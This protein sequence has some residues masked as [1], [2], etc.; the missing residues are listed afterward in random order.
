MGRTVSRVN[1]SLSVGGGY[2]QPLQPQ[3]S[4]H[5][6]YP[7]YSAPAMDSESERFPSQEEEYEVYD[8]DDDFY[9]EHYDD[10][11]D[12]I[13]EDYIGLQGA[14]CD[15]NHFLCQT[16]VRPERWKIFQENI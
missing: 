14:L 3:Y 13:Y 16:Q 8:D 11:E 12:V 4:G 9:E 10:A 6:N 5:Y 15:S 7:G 2:H 1:T